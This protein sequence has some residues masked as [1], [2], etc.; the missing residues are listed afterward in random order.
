MTP[1]GRAE[2]ALGLSL[3]IWSP[4]A[5]AIVSGSIPL[6]LGGLYYLA[7]L[8]IAW[9]GT[10]VIAGIVNNYRGVVDNLE[11]AKREIEEIERRSQDDATAD[12]TAD[13]PQRRKTD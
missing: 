12:T 5:L 1:H 4:V 7:A 3:L 8:A 11:R 10:G 2:W 6:Y 13:T 9:V